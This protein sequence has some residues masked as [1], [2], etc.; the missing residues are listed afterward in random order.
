MNR[1]PKALE[2]I[3]E[4]CDQLRAITEDRAGRASGSNPALAGYSLR[5]LRGRALVIS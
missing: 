3:L 1:N 4:F 5:D 2:G